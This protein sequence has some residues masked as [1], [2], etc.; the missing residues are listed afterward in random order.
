MRDGGAMRFGA[1]GLALAAGCAANVRVDEPIALLPESSWS[2]AQVAALQHAAE[3]WNLQFGTQLV[4]RPRPTVEQQVRVLF[5][6]FVCAI[7]TSLTET[8]PP[9]LSIYVCPLEHFENTDRTAHLFRALIHEMGHVLNIHR[10]GQQTGSI[11]AYGSIYDEFTREDRELF[12]E[13]N[14]GVVLHGACADVR[15]DHATLTCRCE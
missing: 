13:A 1:L 10:E 8:G 3:C 7:A 11:M 14:P 15:I 6:D 4:L 9:S 2:D 12:S 5:N